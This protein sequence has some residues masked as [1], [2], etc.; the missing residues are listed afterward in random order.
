MMMGVAGVEQELDP[1]LTPILEKQ[2]VSKGKSKY[3]TVAGKVCDYSDDF[4]LYLVT[5]LPNPHFSP[6]EQSK[7]T[8]VDF[9]VTQKG[10]FF[11][12]RFIL[13]LKMINFQCIGLEEQLLGRVIQREQRSLE[14][15]LKNVLE[16]VNGNTKSLL[17]LDQ[18]LLERLSE[19]SGEQHLAN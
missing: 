1:L 9:T 10:Q 14:E 15:S 19:N 5:R 12:S 16:E 8:I 2:I 4:M 18:M 17:R 6:E 7:C 11:F 13:I 3:I